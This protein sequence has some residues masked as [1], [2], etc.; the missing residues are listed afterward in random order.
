MCGKTWC[1]EQNIDNKIEEHEPAELNKLLEQFYA[2]N[3]ESNPHTFSCLQSNE[4]VYL[5]LVIV[6]TW[7]V[8]ELSIS[9]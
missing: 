5:A 4:L 8:F 9:Q 2:E 3:F 7:H 6:W 1:Q